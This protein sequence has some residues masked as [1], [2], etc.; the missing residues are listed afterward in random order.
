MCQTCNLPTASLRASNHHPSFHSQSRRTPRDDAKLTVSKM[1]Q[2]ATETR[3]RPP[4]H[5]RARQTLP[6]PFSRHGL[7]PG[8]FD[9]PF[10]VAAP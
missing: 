3:A 8:G 1:R 7:P 2:N 4:A 6:F 5:T 9:I 10:A